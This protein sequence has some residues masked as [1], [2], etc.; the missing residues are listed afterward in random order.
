LGGKIWEGGRGKK[1]KDR[2]KRGIKVKSKKCKSKNAKIKPKI[3]HEENFLVL[4]EKGEKYHLQG[5]G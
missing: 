5:W 4:L 3:V 1:R 2:R